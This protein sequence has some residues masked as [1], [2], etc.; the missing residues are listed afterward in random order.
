M[1]IRQRP[2]R[3]LRPIPRCAHPNVPLLFGGEDHRHGFG[4]DRRDDSVRRCCQEAVDLMRPRHRLGLRAAIPVERRPDARE[5]EQ[6]PVI[7]ECE[8]N[9]ILFLGLRVRLR[10]VLNEAVGRDEARGNKIIDLPPL[11]RAN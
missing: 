3:R 10:R 1:V 8:P 11:P 9:H 7:V 2:L 5:N 6:R 4:M